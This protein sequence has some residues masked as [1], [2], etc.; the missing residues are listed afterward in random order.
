MPRKRIAVLVPG[1]LGSVLEDSAG[2]QIWSDNLYSNYRNL[3][4]NPGLLNWSGNKAAASLL[5]DVHLGF[6]L[7]GISLWRSVY[8]GVRFP[9]DFETSP[10]VHE[11]G[12][13]WR[14]SN[15]ESAHDL[16]AWLTRLL[17]CSVSEPPSPEQDRRITFI[18]H[19]MGGLVVR[20]A[21]A[22][23]VIH[24]QWVDRMIH[25]GSPLAGAP[26][27][28]G[29]LFG[30]ADILPLLS[31]LLDSRYLKNRHQFLHLLQDCIRTTESIFELLPRSQQPYVHYSVLNRANPLQENFIGARQRQLATNA[32]ALLDQAAAMMRAANL[33]SFTIYTYWHPTK[34]T[35]IE[36]RVEPC[37]GGYRILEVTG[38][39]SYGDG[40]V[41]DAS[42]RG[43]I[44]VDHSIPVYGVT[45]SA[46]CR[47]AGVGPLIQSLL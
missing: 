16:A 33:P 5:K 13:D 1:I 29:S 40:K 12:Y 22:T 3:L 42:A 7:S 39:T 34:K 18:M 25:I 43:D 9:G 14:Q 36:Y 11:F 32:H 37:T 2:G 47:H 46:M 45:H 38:M 23:R 28:F 27:A 30:G 8:K 6:P 31:L 35:N 26:S 4:D 10:Y 15:V 20:L 41:P 24:L 17:G 44:T 21:I 19:S